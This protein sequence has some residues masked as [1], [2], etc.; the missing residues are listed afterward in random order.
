MSASIAKAPGRNDLANLAQLGS[1]NTVT[2]NFQQFC[3]IGFN[4]EV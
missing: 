1:V 4:V 2:K 3:S